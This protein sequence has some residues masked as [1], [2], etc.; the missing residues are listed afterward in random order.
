MYAT[1]VGVGMNLI[2]AIGI[3][4]LIMKIPIDNLSV[5]K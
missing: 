5:L 2:L 4:V 1:D 3:G